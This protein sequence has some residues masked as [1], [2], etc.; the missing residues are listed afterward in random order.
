MA[1]KSELMA[2]AQRLG[3]RGRTSMTKADLRMTLTI[4]NHIL[5]R[6]GHS[7]PFAATP[8]CG[9]RM[10]P[11]LVVLHD[12]AGRLDGRSSVEWL[13]NPAAKAS[14]HVVIDRAGRITQLAEFDRITWHAGVSTWDGRPNVNARSIGVEFENP[15]RLVRRGDTAVAWYGQ[16]FDIAA[17][18]IAAIETAAHGA[19]L[20]M[21]YTPEQLAALN[22]LLL[23]IEAVYPIREVVGHYQIAPG[24]KVDPTPLLP[25]GILGVASGGDAQAADPLAQAAQA[26]DQAP[27]P[28][29]APVPIPDPHVTVR[30]LSATSRTIAEQTRA[31]ADGWLQLALGFKSIILAVFSLI[32]DA[33]RAL[34]AAL[35][36]AGVL[37][38]AATVLVVFGGLALLRAGRTIGY[39]VDDA[40]TGKHLGSTA[41]G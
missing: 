1:T 34:L 39:R 9:G 23:A 5:Y 30:D 19:G 28:L 27:P 41:H 36:P 22:D 11:E 4:Y 26:L 20:W 16:A 10:R 32:T 37:A 3:V 2:E 40:R 8:N 25:E 6:D 14:A 24:R 35:G 21:P 29:S 15:G 7:V 38:L 31:K 17:H 33:G 18:G 12:T 13:C